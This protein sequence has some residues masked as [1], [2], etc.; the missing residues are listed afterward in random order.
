M[1]KWTKEQFDCYGWKED[2]FDKFREAVDSSNRSMLKVLSVVGIIVGVAVGIHRVILKPNVVGILLTALLLYAAIRCALIVYSG[3]KERWRILFSGYF[4]SAALYFLSIFAARADGTDAYWVGVQMGLCGFL[5]DYATGPVILQT[6]CFMLL[7]VVKYSF[8]GAFSTMD[9]TTEVV[10][11]L[12]GLTS[13]YIMNRTRVAMILSR[14]ETK[15]QADT[16]LL[17]G[18]TIR[19]AAEDEIEHH[20][21]CSTESSVLILLDL[22]KFKSVNDL[23]GHQM[24]DRVLIEVAS[25][26]RHMFR[27]TDVISRLGG[28]EYI[29]YMKGVPEEE[30]ARMRAE[31]VVDTIRRKIR[32]GDVEVNISASVGY[33]MSA[34]V[35]RTYSEMYRAADLAMYV[36]KSSGG[37]QAIRYSDEL[38]NRPRSAMAADGEAANLR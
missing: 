37:N 19:K 12:L 18:L 31:Q 23:I 24:G 3:E 35:N 28:D 36:A 4:L 13:M 1:K 21:E 16:D 22:D 15:L 17:T 33:V 27:T 11:L 5:L 10:F 30:W 14:E 26:L 34:S 20:L 8:G 32:T 7:M 2:V 29:I 38:M 6:L 25:D 9:L